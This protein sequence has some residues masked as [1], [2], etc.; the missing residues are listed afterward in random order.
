MAI[1]KPSELLL[2]LEELGIHPKKALSQNFLIDGNI[3]RKIV[4]SADVQAGDVVVEIGP[5]PGSLTEELLKAGAHVIAVEKDPVLAKALSRLNDLGGS[6]QISNA[7]ILECSIDQLLAKQL[8]PGQKA[9]VIANLPYHITTP[10]V[11]KFL[12]FHHLISD[13][14]IMIQE[15]VAQRFVGKPFTHQYGS[16][17]VFLNYFSSPKY[18]FKVS[19]NCFYPAPNVDSAIVQLRLR[20]PPSIS[21]ESK[22]FQMTR[23]AFEQ[24][25]KMLRGSLKDIYGSNSIEEALLSIGKTPKA[26]PEELSLDEFIVLFEKLQN[27]NNTNS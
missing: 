13:I 16:I 25:R 3:I 20:T 12:Q 22:F 27:L 15:E 10:I 7:D 21:D 23:R 1:Y 18:L 6:L 14:V 9:K 24:R 19:R 26:R 5:G 8:K 4:S 17:T 2:F 11:I